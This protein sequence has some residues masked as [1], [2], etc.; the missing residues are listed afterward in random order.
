MTKKEAIDKLIGYD[1]AILSPETARGIAQPF[2]LADKVPISHF[3]DDRNEPKGI[4]LN[5]PANNDGIGAHILAH[6]LCRQH[7]VMFQSKFGVGS[8]LRE[9]CVQLYHAIDNGEV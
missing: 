3:T 7:R 4:R 6:W 2:G 8:Q 9:C 1:H 5:D